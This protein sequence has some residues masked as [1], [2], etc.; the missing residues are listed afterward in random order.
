MYNRIMSEQKGFTIIELLTVM[1]V[2]GLL[3]AIIIMGVNPILQFQKA[4]DGKRKADLEQIRSALE[5]YR[6]DTGAYPANNGPTAL[7]QCGNQWTNNGVIYMQ[8]IPCDPLATAGWYDKS[9]AGSY[10]YNNTGAAYTL[11]A[12]LENTKDPQG[13]MSSPGGGTGC[14]NTDYYTVTNP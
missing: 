3:T 2:M 5:Q 4:R 10:Y 12:C 7:P 11:T 1:G 14:T 9:N 13:N 8:K 6:T